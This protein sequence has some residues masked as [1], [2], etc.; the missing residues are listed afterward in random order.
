MD[1]VHPVKAVIPGTQGKV[2]AVLAE[3]SAELNL[4]TA[5][6]LANIS[7]SQASRVLPGL[8]ELGLVERREVPPS[9][10]FRLSRNNVAA[11][12]VIQLARLHDTALEQMGA[13]A[14]AMPLRPASVIIF[15]SF[16][17]READSESD[18]DAVV[19]RPDDIDDDDTWTEG[20]EQ[21]RQDVRAL[22]GNT[23]EVVE[24]PL[25]QAREKLAS[26]S[27]LWRDIIRDGVVIH[28]ATL[29]ELRDV[30]RA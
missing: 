25:S 19:I 7:P 2:L 21:W 14:D 18:I 28:G 22:T 26:R 24:S 29:D 6:R 3:T 8:V 13:A 17:R 5:A 15:G 23:V 30:S 11:K 20:V 27:Q 12:A 1:F 16:A 9:S 10:L 4:R